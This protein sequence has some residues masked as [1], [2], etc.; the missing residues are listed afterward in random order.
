[1]SLSVLRFGSVLDSALCDVLGEGWDWPLSD[2]ESLEEFVSVV[3]RSSI[4][5]Y[6]VFDEGIP[7]GVLEFGL[8]SEDFSFLDLGLFLHKD[9]RGKGL[10]EVLLHSGFV[11]CRELGLPLMATVHEDNG[12]SLGMIRKATGFE[13]V[14]VFEGK[15]NRDAWVFDLSVLE[16]NPVKCSTPVVNVLREDRLFLDKVLDRV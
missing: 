10:A 8:Y 5:A 2:C 12:R 15:R 1:M 13:G 3:Q 7:V 9:F 14:K 6:W 11:A 4:L 16:V